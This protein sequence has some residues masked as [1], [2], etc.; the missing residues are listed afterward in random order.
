MVTS[1][2]NQ[3]TEVPVKSSRNPLFQLMIASVLAAAIGACGPSPSADDDD[4]DDVVDIDASTVNPNCTNPV[5]EVCD[6]GLDDDCDNIGDCDDAD[7]SADSHCVNANCGML[8]TPT[9]S[10]ELPDGAC[11]ADE[12]QP[13]DGYE[14]NLTFTGF[15]Q[16]Q[17]LNDIS[18]LLGFCVNMTHT[19]MR[20]LVIY[21]QCPNGTRVMLSDFEGR[22]G[23]RV[24]LGQPPSVGWD[25]CWTPTATNLP[26]I[27]YSNA[28]TPSTLPAGDYQASEP[29][30]N[31]VGCPLNGNWTIR[32]EDRWGADRGYIY[33]WSVKFDPS[34]VED[35]ANWPG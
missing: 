26:W 31:F 22:T 14:S 9:A 3:L 30:N 4:D 11:P 19:W 6:N 7:C 8:E 5:P 10:L 16:G 29:L 12:T 25:Y 33:N 1:L 28:N 35:C 20:D 32:V 17:T 34:I 13:C 24:N 27:P 2:A 23:G 15:S 18:K 21:G